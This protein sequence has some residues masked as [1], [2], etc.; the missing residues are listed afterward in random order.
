MLANAKY[1]Q[2]TIT[3]QANKQKAIF[4]RL[5]LIFHLFVFPLD[6]MSAM[7]EKV[8]DTLQQMR[9]RTCWLGFIAAELAVRWLEDVEDVEIFLVDDLLLVSTIG[10]LVCVNNARLF[11]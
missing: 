7:V 4:R 9:G 8:Y 6:T 11:H 1:P 10:Y 2:Q 5:K 3:I